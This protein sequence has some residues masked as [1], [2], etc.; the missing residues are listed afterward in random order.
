M[1]PSRIGTPGLWI[2]LHLCGLIH[3]G[4]AQVVSVSLRLD[5]PSIG[6]GQST[7][8]RVLA[9]VVSDQRPNADRIFSWYIDL[10]NASP[11]L[12]RLDFN[13]LIKPTADNDPLTSSRGKPDGANLRGV[14]DTFLNLANA[15][16]NQPVELF[17]VPVEGLA[18]GTATFQVRAGT[19]VPNLTADFIV[20]PTG[21]GDPLLGGDY[22]QAAI[23]L[24][25]GP[26]TDCTPHLTVTQIT[27]NGVLTQVTLAF[28][29]CPGRNHIVEFNH[30]LTPR[31]WQALDGAPHNSGSISDILSE[32][33]RFY[34]IRL[35]SP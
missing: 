23:P 29:P 32:R 28:T 6:V 27:S 9:Q 3:T 4:Q 7:T 1:K 24:Q 35:E 18:Q 8:L 21:G 5:N 14:Y 12:A 34:R 16:V 13:Q 15:G 11:T 22:R 26:A 17:S 25:V 2:L 33:R 19:G 30:N 10:L 20:A 31:A